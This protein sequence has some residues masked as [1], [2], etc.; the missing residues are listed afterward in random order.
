MKKLVM[1]VAAMLISVSAFAGNW[2]LVATDTVWSTFPMMKIYPVN[3]VE[4]YS[5][6]L[7][8]V[9]LGT[10]RIQNA[11]LETKN[12]GQIPLWP[13]QGDY[14]SPRDAAMSF[15]ADQIRNVRLDVMS[16]D[17]HA[18]VQMQIYMR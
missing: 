11:F 4:K 12:H 10:A 7:V 17:K 9:T 14:R 5:D 16:L 18:P 15:P 1:M 2:K 6:I 3:S 13:I 8:R